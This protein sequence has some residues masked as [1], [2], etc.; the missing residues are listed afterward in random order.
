MPKGRIDK[1]KLYQ[2]LAEGKKLTECAKYFGVSPAAV[3]KAKGGVSM[4]VARDLHLQNA[5]RLVDTHLDTVSQ[6]QKINVSANQ[7]LDTCMELQKQEYTGKG[8]NPHALALK[9]MKEIRGQLKLQN[10]TLA[11]LSQMSAVMEFQQELIGLLKE[12]DENVRDEFLRRISQRR[13]LRGAVNLT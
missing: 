12:V 3:H 5:S 11:M 6:L 13:A 10:E 1:D 7:L 9:A 2:L 8:I 4:E